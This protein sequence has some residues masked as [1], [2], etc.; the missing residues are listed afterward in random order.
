MPLARRSRITCRTASVS[1]GVSEAVGSSKIT[2]RC[3]TLRARAICTSWRW[4]IDSVETIEVGLMSAPRPCNTSRAR[5]FITR[6]STTKPRLIS[7]PMK[8]FWA[9]LKCG[10]SRISW[11]TRTMPW[12]SA[13]TGLENSTVLPSSR[14]DPAGR[15]QM[16]GENL[17]QR[18]FAGAVLADQGMHLARHQIERDAEEHLHRPEGHVDRP[19][20]QNRLGR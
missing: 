11:W 18:G 16:A 2:A 8:M 10:A 3:G 19:G 6:S 1:N 7:R 12:R 17:H 4:A 13:S 15:L 20:S 9:T 14:I 5:A